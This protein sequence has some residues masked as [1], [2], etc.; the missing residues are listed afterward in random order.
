MKRKVGEKREREEGRQ[1]KC[2]NLRVIK[3]DFS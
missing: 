3:M 2:L 1:G